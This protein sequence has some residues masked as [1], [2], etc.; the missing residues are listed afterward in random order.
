MNLRNRLAKLE[1]QVFR[2]RNDVPTVVF[3]DDGG[4]IIHAHSGEPS[5][6]DEVARRW[7]GRPASELPREQPIKL[8]S[9]FAPE[10]VNA[11]PEPRPCER[12]K[13]TS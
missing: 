8:Y 7:L 6:A 13:T 2:H 11:P 9:G 5:N 3:V 1:G 4:T 12:A 10:V